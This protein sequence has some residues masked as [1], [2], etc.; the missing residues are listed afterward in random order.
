M[1]VIRIL[2]SDDTG[3]RG[4]VRRVPFS[5]IQTP[6]TIG[7]SSASSAA[8]GGS[9]RIVTVQADADCHIAFGKTPTATAS[10]F[11][12]L[13]GTTDDFEVQGGHKVAVIQA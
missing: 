11:K 8:F 3:E 7:A 6:V 4:T 12:L 2:E 13:A 10:N 9:T 5:V 1:A